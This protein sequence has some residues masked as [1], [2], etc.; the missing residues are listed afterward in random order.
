MILVIFDIY[1]FFGSI[2]IKYFLLQVHGKEI[3]EFNFPR[4]VHV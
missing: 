4:K 3:N 2:I 1:Y